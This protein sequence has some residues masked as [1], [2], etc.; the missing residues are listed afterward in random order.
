MQPFVLVTEQVFSNYDC[1]Y[2][3]TITSFNR[4]LDF[5]KAICLSL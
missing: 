4:R 2:V 5:C 1:I 3:F